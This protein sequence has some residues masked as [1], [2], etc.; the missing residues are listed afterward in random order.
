[1]TKPILIPA[2]SGAPRCA[3]PDTSS[4]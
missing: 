1:M 4:W 2:D 3:F